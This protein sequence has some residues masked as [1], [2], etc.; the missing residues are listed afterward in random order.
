[1]HTR[2]IVSYVILLIGSV[3][4]FNC[5]VWT[6]E[7]LLQPVEDDI[8]LGREVSKQV[9][10][11]MGIIDN[12][13]LTSYL[14]DIGQRLTKKIPNRRFDYTFQV[15]DQA[16]PNAFAAPGGYVYI[17][18]GLLALT[19]SEDELA[20]VVGHEIVHVGQ[21]H[22][23]RQMAKG[24]LPGLLSL[25]GKVVGRVIS[26]DIGNLLNVPVNIFGTT[27]MAAHS[28][29]HE[30]EADG[31][32]QKLAAGA[33]YN[34]HAFAVILDNLEKETSLRI[35][36]KSKISFFSTHPM[37]PRRVKNLANQ[38][39]TIKWLRTPG[40]AADQSV[41]LGKLDGLMIGTNPAKGIFREQNFL[42]P[43]L[44]I[45][46]EF[47]K[48]WQ[49]INTPTAVGAISEK[50][51]GMA[52]V[53]VQGEGED[54]KKAAQEFRKALKKE[55]GTEPSK[56]MSL[57]MGKWPAYLLTYTDKSGREP[58]N[59]HFLWVA[60]RGLIY[61][62]IGLG[63]EYHRESLRKTAYSLRPLTAKEK[64]SFRVTHLRIV[65]AK[66]GENLINLSKRTSNKWNLKTTALMNGL[67]VSKTLRQGQ[68]IKITV[69]EKYKEV[70]GK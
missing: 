26:R 23:A 21:R 70:R 8:K 64:A 49:T 9:E 47:P 59:M 20:N 25:P 62:M 18:R 24:R 7:V 5:A 68:L 30:M 52:I 57:K 28:R 1:M 34:P 54:P 66:D 61:Q 31:L 32:G 41:F 56:T 33:G 51:D 19:N 12:H 44:D 46:I 38:S 55:F 13:A 58:M 14:N 27:V 37:T 48:G 63:P 67:D 3:V 17:S 53:G 35:G 22:T 42:H 4:L 36:E 45:F 29:Q 40:I 50:D 60:V 16:E 15:V 39:K 43:E 65:S 69:S 2:F 11:Q 10:S 6:P